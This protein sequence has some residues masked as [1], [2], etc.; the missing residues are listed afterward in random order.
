MD[1]FHFVDPKTNPYLPLEI[2]E[3]LAPSLRALHGDPVSFWVGQFVEYMCRPQ[4]SIREMFREFAK[5][6]KFQNPIVGLVSAVKLNDQN[7]QGNGGEGKQF[8]SG[9][10]RNFGERKN[11]F[12]SNILF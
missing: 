5:N 11:S 9:T 7:L 2:P 1:I 12:L 6:V 3:D 10:L 8:L 4:P